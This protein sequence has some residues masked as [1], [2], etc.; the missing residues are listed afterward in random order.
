MWNSRGYGS[1]LDAFDILGTPEPSCL[2]LLGTG[3]MGALGAIW[4]KK[5]AK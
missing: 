1:T 5:L 2:L 3:F 4:F